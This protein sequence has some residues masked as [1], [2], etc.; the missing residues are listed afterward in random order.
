MSGL[1]R[2]LF[3]ENPMQ[4]ETLRAVRRF[5][6]TSGRTAAIQRNVV[7]MLIGLFCAVY[8]WFLLTIAAYREDISTGILW[9]EF[10]LVTLVVPGSLYAAISGERERL[11]WD[12]LIMTNLTP[13]RILT[14]KLL[15]RLGMAGAILLLFMPPLLLT[16]FVT[17]FAAAYSLSDMLWIQVCMAAWCVF[18]AAFTLWVSAKT[19]RSVVTLSVVMVSLIAGLA[20]VPAL[21]MVFSAPVLVSNPYS[22]GLASEEWGSPSPI[23]LLGS[24]LVHLNPA[25]VIGALCVQ[26]GQS[27]TDFWRDFLVPGYSDAR[28][29]G[30]FTIL[31]I[32]Y[33]GLAALCLT[34]TLKA[35]ARLGL[36]SGT[37]R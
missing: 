8:A 20:L 19:K 35:L 24:L 21:M 14:G 11:T 33:L 28:G 1:W 3:R 17:K 6:V 22:Y 37:T 5:S 2:Y 15:W 23:M 18:L 25:Y 9:F 26:G 36:P 7:R 30:I 4:I 27:S 34:R 12:S 32:I 10:V 13:A 29:M 16:H 31:P